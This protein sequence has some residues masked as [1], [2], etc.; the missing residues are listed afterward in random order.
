MTEEKLIEQINAGNEV[1]LKEIF[2]KYL[3][4]V[5]S[6]GGHYYF[7]DLDTKDWEQEAFILCVESAK[8]YQA[9]KGRSFGNF[10]KMR[11][12]NHAKNL[13][14][15]EFAKCRAKYLTYSYENL[16]ELGLISEPSFNQPIIPSNLEFQQFI[17]RLSY[18][19]LIGLMSLLGIYDLEE[20]SKKLN[21]E[22]KILKRAQH[23]TKRK[24]KSY[25]FN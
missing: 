5:H 7:K 8:L 21:I 22:L 18:L 6:I 20:S 9:E 23:R 15:Y 1:A 10:F 14:R 19:E 12:Q 4:L 3:P 11:L 24:M 17:Q 13:L 16:Q 2:Q 25:F